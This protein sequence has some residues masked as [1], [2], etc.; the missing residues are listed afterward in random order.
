[1]AVFGLTRVP[2]ARWPLLIA[3]IV[4]L[5]LAAW[6]AFLLARHGVIGA[7]TSLGPKFE[8]LHAIVFFFGPPALAN[9][10]VFAPRR[11]LRDWKL[12]ALATF[13]VAIGF[14]FWNYD[15]QET[16][17]GPDGMG[18]PFSTDQ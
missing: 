2:F 17:Y 11:P 8:T 10:L 3:S 9:I 14:V 13:F 15:L 1:L 18:G 5:A 16:L 6:E 12:V 4:L 7:R